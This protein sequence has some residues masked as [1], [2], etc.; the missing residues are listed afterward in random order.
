MSPQPAPSAWGAW[1]AEL[2]VAPPAPHEPGAGERA[3]ASGTHLGCASHHSQI[4][5]SSGVP[6]SGDTDT[7]LTTPRILPTV[8]VISVQI[9]K[10]TRGE[11]GTAW[12]PCSPEHV[13]LPPASLTPG[14]CGTAREWRQLGG[15]LVEDALTRSAARLLDRK[16]TRSYYKDSG[17][18]QMLSLLLVVSKHRMRFSKGK[19]NTQKAYCIKYSSD[20]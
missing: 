10:R 12:E 7:F 1:I 19:P 8:S 15:V 11:A 14:P 6:V 3:Q 16:Q 2:P 13:P 4:T 9:K 18:A 17:T 20:L 5:P